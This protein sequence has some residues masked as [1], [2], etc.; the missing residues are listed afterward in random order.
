[1]LRVKVR[2][3][4]GYGVSPVMLRVTVRVRDGYGVS[5]VMLRGK[6][7]VRETVGLARSPPP[8]VLADLGFP[9]L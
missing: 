1:M 6:G 7:G 2:V 9:P 5:P 3:R 8:S 4:D